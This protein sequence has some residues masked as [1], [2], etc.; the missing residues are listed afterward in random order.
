MPSLQRKP[1]DFQDEEM[2]V[3]VYSLVEARAGN[4]DQEWLHAEIRLHRHIYCSARRQ[5]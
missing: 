2:R 3:T 4:G 5:E 1:Q